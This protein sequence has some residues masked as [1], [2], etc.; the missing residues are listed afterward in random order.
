MNTDHE[1]SPSAAVAAT[2]VPPRAKASN[3]REPY[4]SRMANREKRAL[5]GFFG[6][7][8]FGAKPRHAPARRGVGAAARAQPQQETIYLLDGHPTL[9]TES[10]ETSLE[11]GMCAGFPAGGGAHHLVDRTYRAVVIVE[12]GDRASADSVRYPNDDIQTVSAATERGGSRA[13]TARPPRD[14]STFVCKPPT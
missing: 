7:R 1:C 6:L 4:V 14:L 11:P 12:I 9:L 3:Y 5:G 13:R 2:D 8:N 10:G